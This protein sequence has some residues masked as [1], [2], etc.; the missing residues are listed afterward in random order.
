[1]RGSG[2]G[3]KV[4]GFGVSSDIGV[5]L[6]LAGLDDVVTLSFE[7]ELTLCVG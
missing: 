3:D 4:N 5:G 7:N 2:P 1:M 6:A